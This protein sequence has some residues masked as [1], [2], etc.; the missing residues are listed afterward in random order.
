MNQETM[1]WLRQI[2]GPT[3]PISAEGVKIED[4]QAALKKYPN[5]PAIE[6][7]IWEKYNGAEWVL[8]PEAAVKEVFDEMTQQGVFDQAGPDNA[9]VLDFPKRQKPRRRR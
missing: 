6:R 3:L 8:F 2:F 9:K 1:H 4:L 7:L 5:G